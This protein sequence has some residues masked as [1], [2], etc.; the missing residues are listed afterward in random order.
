MQHRVACPGASHNELN[1]AQGFNRNEKRLHYVTSLLQI[2]HVVNPQD[3]C[4]VTAGA[5]ASDAAVLKVAVPLLP[6]RF[7]GPCGLLAAVQAEMLLVAADSVTAPAH[8]TLEAAVERMLQRAALANAD[9]G[10]KRCLRSVTRLL[11]GACGSSLA[12]SAPVEDKGDDGIAAEVELECSCACG[13]PASMCLNW[14]GRLWCT[15]QVWAL[16]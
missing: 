12:A 16:L 1:A 2:P 3:I 14:S 15:L 10:G 7:N 5:R 11:C 8:T 6:Q 4:P 9:S 13:C